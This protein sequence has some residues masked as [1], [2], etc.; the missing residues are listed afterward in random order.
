M[1]HVREFKGSIQII[2]RSRR[3]HSAVTTENMTQ[4]YDYILNNAYYEFKYT[5][6]QCIVQKKEHD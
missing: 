6:W 1:K 3:S 2:H 4:Q 5:R